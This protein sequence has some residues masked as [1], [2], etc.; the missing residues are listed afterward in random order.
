M[1]ENINKAYLCFIVTDRIIIFVH[2]YN[3]DTGK[4]VTFKLIVNHCITIFIY[5]SYTIMF[6]GH[7]GL[8]LMF[9]IIF[10]YVYNLDTGIQYM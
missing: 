6:K 10:V 5:V 1:I 9:R 3:L 2:V 4:Y 7:I 8:Y